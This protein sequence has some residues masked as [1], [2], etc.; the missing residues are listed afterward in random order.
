MARRFAFRLE[1]LLRVR[2]LRER[3]AKRK[4][5]AKR[6][7]IALLDRLDRQTAEE[8]SR[9]Q[10]DLLAG[11]RDGRLDPLALQRGRAW[12]GHLRR[13]VALRQV[14]RVDLVRQWQQLQAAWHAARTQARIIEKLRERRWAEYQHDRARQEQAAADELAQQLHEH[15]E[16]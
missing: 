14:Q 6:A 10:A 15:R 1:T 11:Q 2:Q 4:V 3:E 16:M 13:M 9:Q 8:I 12:L 7:E 5:A